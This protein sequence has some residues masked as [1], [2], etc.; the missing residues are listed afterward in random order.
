MNLKLNQIP[1]QMQP[2]RQWI[3]W[4]SEERSGK[5]TKVPYAVDGRLAS[6]TDPATWSDFTTAVERYTA[7]GYTGVGFVFTDDDPFVGIDLDGCRGSD[8][9]VSDWAREIIL[10]LNTYAEVSPSETGVKLFVQGV[11]HQTGKK[12]EFT[13]KDRPTEKTPAIEIYGRGRYFA[14]T[15]VMLKGPAEPQERQDEINALYE[16]FWAVKREIPFQQD[17]YSTTAVVERARRYISTMPVAVSG[18][19]G[20]NTTFRVAC[21]LMLGFG[22]SDTEAMGLLREWNQGCDPPWSDRELEHKI[23]SAGNQPGDKG[24]LRNA[25]PQQWQRVAV[26]TYEEPKSTVRI[27]TLE[28]AT[29]KYLDHL[30]DGKNALIELGLPDV[31][32]AIGGGV[33]KGEVV[34]LAGRPSHGKSA[35]AMQCVHN[36]TSNGMP[37]LVISE[38]M[39]AITIG[40]RAIQ[41]IS[42]VPEEHWPT[43]REKLDRQLEDHFEK[44]A[45]CYVIESV[46]TPE[47]A[48]ERIRWAVR[49]HGVEVVALD[50]AQLLRGQG[51]SIYE[52]LTNTSLMLRQ[53]TNECNVLLLLL[54]Q[55]NR[56]IEKR[57]SFTPKMSD[58]RE[59]GQFEQDAD[60]ILFLCWPH[61]IDPAKDPH[62]YLV[63]VAKNRNR[64]INSPVVKCKFNPSR[65]RLDYARNSKRTTYQP[66]KVTEDEPDKWGLSEEF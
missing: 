45:Q 63:F 5:P 51:K 24:Y 30:G 36:A 16:Q 39:S 43:S 14:M 23:K 35:I 3:L 53:V 61:R 57:P 18:Q 29:R 12:H 19:N 1:K 55:L 17:F 59:T 27:T 7:G 22:L 2:Y 56:E 50:Y 52:Q 4:R 32:Y 65:Q 6:V 28:E 37:A 47:I 38:E 31:D 25:V 44:Q 58:L 62:E 60:V 11:W 13:G 41:F 21:V 20:H 42:G 34:I 9:K 40:K 8:G 46:A 26:P 15:G 10:G 54:C 64:A 49:E 33:A 48:A 66:L